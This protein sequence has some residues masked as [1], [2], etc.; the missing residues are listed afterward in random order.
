[1]GALPGLVQQLRTRAIGNVHEIPAKKVP[2]MV[3]Q[4]TSAFIAIAS[5]VAYQVSIKSIPHDL[6]PISA[7]VTFYVT[8]LVCTLVVARFVPVSM[9]SWSMTEF[10]W[11]AVMVGIA[12]VGIELGFLLMYR[13]GWNLAVAPLV[14]MGSATVLLVPIAVFAFRQPFSARYLFG[15]AL[16]LYGLYL[17]APQ[18]Q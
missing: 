18:R 4:T 12:I 11:A 1:M 15:L 13:S 6:N 17:L 5:V 16:C 14:T 10:S 8:A 7:L 2:V 3:T 9:P